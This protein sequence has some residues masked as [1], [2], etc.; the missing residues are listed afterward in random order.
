[1]HPAPLLVMAPPG[2]SASLVAAMLG[3]HPQAQDLPELNLFLAPNLD[4][5]LQIAQLSDGLSA[6]GLW[7]AVAQFGFGAQTVETV[8]A[9]QH[10]LRRRADWSGGALLRSLA[11]QLAPRLLVTPET[12]CGWRI[13]DLERCL[14]ENADARVL[15]LVEH[16]RAYCRERVAALSGRLFV[17]PDFKDYNARPPTLDPQIAWLRVHTQLR[18]NLAGW[19]AAQVRVLAMERLLTRPEPTLRSLLD[20]LGLPATEAAL[21]AMQR[22]E[23]SAFASFGP[24]GA[25]LGYDE[26]FLNAPW[27]ERR[28][29]V[30]ETLEGPLEWRDQGMGFAA[31]VK[32]LAGEFGY[33]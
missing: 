10:W 33:A 25:R 8:A 13:K 6:E 3:C 9:A 12:S 31:E 26:A 4:E 1:M 30:S 27:F 29:G 5:L 11:A 22:P 17:P 7:R 14:R 32:S 18:A 21:H 15:H 28:I 24:Q 19:P 23:L 20:W 2:R 16:P